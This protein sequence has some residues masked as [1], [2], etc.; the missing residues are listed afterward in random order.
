MWV[1]EEE[2]LCSYGHYSY[3]LVGYLQPCESG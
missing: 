3:Q 2:E 1:D